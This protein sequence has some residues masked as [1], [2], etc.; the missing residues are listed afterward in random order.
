MS[1]KW[2]CGRARQAVTHGLGSV[3]WRCRIQLQRRSFNTSGRSQSDIHS[4]VSERK[5]LQLSMNIKKPPQVLKIWRLSVRPKDISFAFRAAADYFNP[6]PMR[7][8]YMHTDREFAGFS[9]DD[10]RTKSQLEPVT[11]TELEG[12]E[13][14]V[15]FSCAAKSSEEPEKSAAK[16]SEE[17]G[18]NMRAIFE[19]ALLLAKENIDQHLED[20]K[21]NL[22]ITASQAGKSPEDLKSA[23]GNMNQK[24]YVTTA[25]DE[26]QASV[27]QKPDSDGKITVG[28]RKAVVNIEETIDQVAEQSSS[29]SASEFRSQRVH[30]NSEY[31]RRSSQFEP[32]LYSENFGRFTNSNIQPTFRTI[33]RSFTSSQGRC[34]ATT[35]V[36]PHSKSSSNITPLT[37]EGHAYHARKQ[38]ICYPGFRCMGI[39]CS[40]FEHSRRPSSMAGAPA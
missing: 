32:R 13:K 2:A 28:P 36:G 18:N 26:A 8:Y 33:V 20:N 10:T 31:R 7:Y 9:T 5:K 24:E 17:L 34:Y 29:H 11:Q 16:S 39:R 1:G 23:N 30:T 40:S 14:L 6:D 19:K 25:L 27:K 12:P 37:S 35:S 22:H 21:G 38:R 4:M 15:T 3:C